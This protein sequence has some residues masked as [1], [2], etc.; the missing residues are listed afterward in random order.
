MG[1]VGAGRGDM[2]ERVCS[3][4]WVEPGLGARANRVVYVA[5]NRNR[6]VLEVDTERWEV[7]RRLSTGKAPYNLE[8][9]ADGER[10]IATLKGEQAV[11]VFDL[12]SGAEIGR[13]GTSRPV[14]HGVVA[15]PDGRYVFVS[16]ES[17]GSVRGTL[18][19]IDLETLAVAA[20]V[21]LEHQSGGI[22]FWM[23]SPVAG[24]VR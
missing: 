10:L 21:E 3:P 23:G 13:V 9:T 5:C 17:V 24:G 7:S 11:A 22:G 18:D 19:V 1:E 12:G 15:S 20:T 6:E 14:T 4:T 2:E 8:V 16:N